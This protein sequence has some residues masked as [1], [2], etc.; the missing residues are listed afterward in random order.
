MKI[1]DFKQKIINNLYQI[2]FDPRQKV[3]LIIRDSLLVLLRVVRPTSPPTCHMTFSSNLE[4]K[5]KHI[6]T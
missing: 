4:K 2:K 1:Y 6:P 3:V 5:V